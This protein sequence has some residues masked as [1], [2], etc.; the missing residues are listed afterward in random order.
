MLADS[1]EVDPGVEYVM[2]PKYDGH[3]IL[4]LIL[5]DG[6]TLYARSG[7][8]KTRLMPNIVESLRDLPHGTVLDGEVVSWTETGGDWAKVQSV[9]GS[10][11]KAGLTL[12]YVVFDCLAVMGEDVRLH[13]QHVRREF[14]ERML[15]RDGD[16][17]GYVRITEQHP[18]DPDRADELMADGWE[19]AI[20]K[21]VRGTYTAGRHVGGWLKIKA[22]ETEDVV[23]IGATPGKGRLTGMIGALEFALWDGPDNT[24]G[25]IIA[26]IG[27]GLLGGTR[28]ASSSRRCTTRARSREP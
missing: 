18:Y 12:T 17:D 13:P 14:I 20:L 16:E 6:V 15:W 25:P 28:F 1:R 11:D 24:I 26:G 22:S 3:R 10:N 27:F 8:D 9:L 23:V 21:P 7:V 4:A 5:K 19:G 2:E